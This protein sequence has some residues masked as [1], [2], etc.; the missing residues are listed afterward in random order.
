MDDPRLPSYSHGVSNTPILGETIAQNFD[1][2]CVNFA[3]NDAIVGLHENKR[4]T[5]AQLHAEV[6]RAA[7]AL[8]ALGIDK[9]ERVG[10]WATNRTEWTIVQFATAKIGAILVNINPAN[11]RN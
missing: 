6:V 1:R 11:Q 4:L 10:I 9:G 8:I 5:Y 3:A 2:A 7:R